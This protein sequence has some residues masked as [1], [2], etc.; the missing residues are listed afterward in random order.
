MTN[1]LDLVRRYWPSKLRAG[2]DALFALD[3]AMGD[4][5]RST[6][7]P[8]IGRIRLAWWRERL[9]DLDG[10]KVPDEPRLREAARLLLPR[11]I[12]G[13]ELAALEAG[14]T[15]LFDPFPWDGAVADAIC[16]RGAGL[17]GA[18]AKL[19]GRND[20][21]I[22]TTG[23]LWALVDVARHC[24]DAESR[25]ALI[26]R[27]GQISSELSGKQIAKPLRPV[28]MLTVLAQ[29]DLTHWPAI[30]PRDAPGRALALLRHRVGGRL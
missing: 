26:S 29:R 12:A 11:G 22:R 5:L 4:V 1:D 14:W 16:K 20:E 19:L 8:M 3:A 28:S 21:R 17:F 7:E 18:A 30:E 6:S 24:S 15:R 9:E 13:A 10:G 23:S 25:N 2:S 27:A